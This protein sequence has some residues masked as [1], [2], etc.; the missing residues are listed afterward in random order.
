M[1]LKQKQSQKLRLGLG[2]WSACLVG[3]TPWVPSP[4]WHKLGV[5][6]HTCNHST[7]VGEGGRKRRSLG[8]PL[9]SLSQKKFLKFI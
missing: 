6:V 4:A 1:I 9:A 3:T 5:K 8:S 7:A 2:G